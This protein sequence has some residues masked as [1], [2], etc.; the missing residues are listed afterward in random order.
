MPGAQGT[1]YFTSL[2]KRVYNAGL[3]T[4]QSN[5]I[6]VYENLAQLWNWPLF[7]KMH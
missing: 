5:N 3:I 2:V 6:R 7:I 4:P 1:D